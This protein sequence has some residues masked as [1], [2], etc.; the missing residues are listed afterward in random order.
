VLTHKTKKTILKDNYSVIP[1]GV[2]FFTKSGTIFT[3]KKWGKTALYNEETSK[4]EIMKNLIKTIAVTATLLTATTAS[5]EVCD[6]RPSKSV[7]TAA[8]TVAGAGAS[9]TGAAAVASPY[10]AIGGMVGSTAVGTSGAGTVGIISGT[11]G[12]AGTAFAI[13][14]SPITITAGA[15]IVGSAAVFE[16]AC[17]LLGN[18]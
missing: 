13:L 18:K 8:I 3:S 4:D 17:T 6:Y 14:T 11:A 2:A 1:S 15:V 7:T 9:L 16:G 12:I 10:Y 5:A